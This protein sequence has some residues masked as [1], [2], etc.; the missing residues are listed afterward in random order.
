MKIYQIIKFNFYTS[1]HSIVGDDDEGKV[2]TPQEY[3]EYKKSVLPM[4]MNLLEI[5]LL[6]YR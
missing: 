1:F 6:D 3:E 2:F 4:V 5:F